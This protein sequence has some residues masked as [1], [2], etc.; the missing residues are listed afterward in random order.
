ML[1]QVAKVVAETARRSDIGRVTWAGTGGFP[2]LAV[3]FILLS[4]VPLA[5]RA[6]R[7][8]AHLSSAERDGWQTAELVGSHSR[9]SNS[10][11]AT[12][13]DMKLWVGFY[14]NSLETSK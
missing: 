12:Q 9:N 6:N 14:R 1:L 5:D 7:V 3:S 8:I 10:E 13:R 4:A 2:P 11:E